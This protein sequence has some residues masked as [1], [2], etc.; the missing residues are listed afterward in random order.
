MSLLGVPELTRSSPY[1][2]DGFIFWGGELADRGMR[3]CLETPQPFSPFEPLTTV[4]QHNVLALFKAIYVFRDFSHTKENIRAVTEAIGWQAKTNGEG[5]V[6]ELDAGDANGNENCTIRIINRYVRARVVF[7]QDHSP[8]YLPPSTSDLAREI[9]PLVDFYRSLELHFPLFPMTDVQHEHFN[10]TRAVW[11][12]MYTECPETL[13]SDITALPA[14]EATAVQDEQGVYKD[15]I[16]GDDWPSNDKFIVACPVA[17]PKGKGKAIM[18]EPTSNNPCSSLIASATAL[19]TG[20][21][22]QPSLYASHMDDMVHTSRKPKIKDP[23]HH[24]SLQGNTFPPSI[25]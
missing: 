24:V 14:I 22:I 23:H 15:T 17:S 19:A 11:D 18:P 6:S 10:A 8:N 2:L 9:C 25:L 20:E 13:L 12:K 1:W 3:R 7:L 4:V 5:L 21:L 16:I